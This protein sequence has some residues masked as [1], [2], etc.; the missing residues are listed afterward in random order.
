MKKTVTYIGGQHLLIIILIDFNF[1][2]FS[3]FQFYSGVLGV[4]EHEYGV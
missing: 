3:L 1:I 4:A 2:Q